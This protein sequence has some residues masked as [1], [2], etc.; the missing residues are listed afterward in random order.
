VVLGALAGS[1]GCAPQATTDYQGDALFSMTGHVEAQLSDSSDDPLIPSIAFLTPE[2]DAIRFVDA[3][4]QG[5]FPAQFQIDLYTPPPAESVDGWAW[6]D[7]PEEP[8]Y[9]IGYISAVTQEHLPV[10]YYSS[11]L[12]STDEDC[13]DTHCDQ[14]FDAKNIDASHSGTVTV[15]C[16]N[17]PPVAQPTDPFPGL[18]DCRVTERSGDPMFVSFL[19]DPMFAGAVTNYALAYL[20]GD[21]PAGGVTARLFGS[22]DGLSAGYHLMHWQHQALDP[23]DEQTKQ[24]CRDGVVQIA[25]ERYNAAHDTQV[26]PNDRFV[27]N[28]T[29]PGCDM[30]RSN[31]RALRGE[32]YRV[33]AEMDCLPGPHYTPVENPASESISLQ[34]SPGLSFSLAGF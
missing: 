22:P 4:V 1:S 12:A 16:P 23:V 34:V 15:R 20:D 9:T 33:M 21:A 17:P 31:T 24:D 8:H 30:F 25:V 14:T 11:V 32:W 7:L 19:P 27:T 2:Q 10:L 13:D 28:C 29:E 26:A 6:E 5:E 18:G 3:D